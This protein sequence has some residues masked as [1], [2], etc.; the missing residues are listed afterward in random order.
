MKIKI[1]SVGS[2]SPGW[3]R[4][5]YE[6][7]AKRLPREL[8]LTLIEIPAPKHQGRAERFIRIEGDKMLAQIQPADWVVA[9][10]EGG[11]SVS[12]EQLARKMDNW[13]MNGRPVAICVGGAD[14]LAPEVRQRADE[15]LSLSALTFPH[16]LVRVVLAEALYRA[17]TI[18]VGHPYHR[19]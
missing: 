15:T 2:K 5:G 6:E 1:I 4:A 7:Y 11:R 3:V 16:Y 8:P 12:S 13:R 14:G 9:L 19:E 10:D 18:N 17:W